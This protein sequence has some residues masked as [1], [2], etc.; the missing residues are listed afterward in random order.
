MLHRTLRLLGG[1]YRSLSHPLSLA[2]HTK[3]SPAPEEDLA[4]VDSETYVERIFPLNHECEKKTM[5]MESVQ[6]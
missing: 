3:N 2:E 1:A 4:A 5:T 6:K